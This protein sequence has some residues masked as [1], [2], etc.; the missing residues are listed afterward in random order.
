V[1]PVAGVVATWNTSEGVNA[2]PG[3]PFPI[4]G[5]VASGYGPASTLAGRRD[6]GTIG[7]VM[8]QVAV[9]RAKGISQQ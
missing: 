1:V 4:I 3:L 9:V 2:V 6:V 5:P 8:F 7:L